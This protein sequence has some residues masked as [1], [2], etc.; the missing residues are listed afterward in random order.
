MVQSIF[1]LRKMKF[2]S[3][4]FFAYLPSLHLLFF[5]HICVSWK[6][7]KFSSVIAPLQNLKQL[8]P[9][10]IRTLDPE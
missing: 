1:K 7:S 3:L 5:T 10:S 6:V 4:N 8:P 9:N 2:K